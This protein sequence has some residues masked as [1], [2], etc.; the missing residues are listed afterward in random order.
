MNSGIIDLIIRIKNGYLAKKEVIVCPHSTFREGIVKKLTE[1]NF[2][3]DYKV[4]GDG[5]K[6][7]EMTLNYPDGQGAFTDVKL[8]SR[9]GRRWYVTSKDLKP[10]L[11]GMGYSLISTSK[12]ILT[13]V[14]AKKAKIGG[15][16]LFDIW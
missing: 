9:P 5:K 4:E 1:L 2:I 14:E 3:K 7:I 6:V 15:E 16:L 12:G 11:S 10:V 13:N 8:Y